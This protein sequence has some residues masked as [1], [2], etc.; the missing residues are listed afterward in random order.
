[1]VSDREDF[2]RDVYPALR[3]FAAVVADLDV[4]PDE[5]VQDALTGFLSIE[6]D[7]VRNPL[8][9]LRRA[10]LHASIRERARR[11][12]QRHAQRAL[13]DAHRGPML[14]DYPTSARAIVELVAPRDR[15]LLFLLDVERKR[16][17]DAAE[18]LGITPVVAR[19]R[20]SRARR[21]LRQHFHEED[22]DS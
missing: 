9:Y 10:I 19:A 14:P 22:M 5:L 7:T 6:R 8:A 18:V 20:A 4:E 11:T 21:A 17:G 12:G 13:R 3:R 1:M 15:A 2:F 16:V